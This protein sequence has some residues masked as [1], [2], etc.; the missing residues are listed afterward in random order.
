MPAVLILSNGGQTF[1]S[2]GGI[3]RMI[4]GAAVRRT[5]RGIMQDQYEIRRP[6]I[7]DP[8]IVVANH[9]SDDHDQ[10]ERARKAKKGR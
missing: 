2:P 4:D 10:L 1:V 5:H 9:Y 3:A 8:A 7:D 6:D